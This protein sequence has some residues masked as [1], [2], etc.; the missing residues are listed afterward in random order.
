MA[1]VRWLLAAT[2]AVAPVFV[3]V[4]P[5]SADS[6]VTA[7]NKSEDSEAKSGD[8][9]SSN[10]S[11]GYTGQQSS[12][13]D[14]VVRSSDVEDSEG[15]N[16]QEGD[17]E[18]EIEQ[19]SNVSTG[20]AVAGQVIGGVVEDGDLTINATNVSEDVSVETGD[21]TGTNTVAAFVGLV[22][23]G[24]DTTIA[25]IENVD[26]TNILEG[27]NDAS[28]DQNVNASSGDGVGGQVLGA[29]VNGGST[30]I[31]AANRSEDVDIETGE[32]DAANELAA[33]VGLNASAGGL[34]VGLGVDPDTTTGT[35]GAA[36]VANSNGVNVQEG[37][38]DFDA[39]Q[40][41]TS[42]SGDGVAGQV[43]GVVSAGDTTI[44]ASNV[45]T[46]V[47]VSTGEATT[48][49][50]A[51]AFVGLAAASSTAVGADIDNVDAN[52]VQE[53][54]NSASLTQASEV[55]TGDAVGGQVAGVVTSAGGSTDVVLD[56]VSEDADLESGDGD[57]VNLQALFTGL[58]T[59]ATQTVVASERTGDDVL[60]S[61]FNF[62]TS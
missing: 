10:N 38:N 46:D 32:V 47:D 5:A 56:N 61:I 55:I 24:G 54:D 36:D 22:A 13:G 25:D 4:A 34:A 37:D 1:L 27:D 39:S 21:A 29:V 43:L 40:S 23:S 51:A 9:N 48:D 6:E 57:M 60:G 12:D 62:A 15:A 11:S 8:V 17:N 35:A 7:D 14:T 26:A 52:N 16:V 30:D 44:D 2:L 18:V 45:S 49:N 50:R 53:G 42:I 3:N 28:I 58:N 59:T 33:F 19:E 20:D 41:A 31:T